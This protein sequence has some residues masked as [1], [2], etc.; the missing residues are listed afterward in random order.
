MCVAGTDGAVAV[1]SEAPSVADS[2]RQLLDLGGVAAGSG[3]VHLGAVCG[4]NPSKDFCLAVD[5][6]L[7]LLARH[8]LPVQRV[9]NGVAPTGRQFQEIVGVDDQMGAGIGGVT[10]LGFARSACIEDEAGERVRRPLH[11]C[12]M[13]LGTLVAA[14]PLAALGPLE[15]LEDRLADDG[16]DDEVEPVVA[17]FVDAVREAAKVLLAQE[18]DPRRR[19]VF[20]ALGLL[21]QVTCGVGGAGF[22]RLLEQFIDP[23]RTEPRARE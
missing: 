7:P 13:L 3:E 9:S 2:Q 20:V 11:R 14:L 5:E 4:Q 21:N 19:F 17:V 15:Q 6:L 10:G 12:A 23:F 18:P 8:G 22:D 16:V 1:I